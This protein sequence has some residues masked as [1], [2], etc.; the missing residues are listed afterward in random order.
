MKIS[1]KARY[2]LRALVDLAVHS[3]GEQVP[4]AHIA[5]RQSLSINYLEQVFALLK[6]AGIV[7]SVKGAQGGY[8]LAR[9]AS[10]IRVSDVIQ[11]IEGNI[12]IVEEEQKHN[13]MSLL[14]QNLQE[15]LQRQVWDKMTESVYKVMNEITL[16]ELMRDYQ[17]LMHDDL[18]MYYI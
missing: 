11:A 5:K 14:Y 13:E 16:E 7:K 17:T 6:K 9:E 10:S 2:G 8:V 3:T 15:C 4:L 18:N 12:I 1:T